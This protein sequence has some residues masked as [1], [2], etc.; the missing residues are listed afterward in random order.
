[1]RTIARV[2]EDPEMT[3][4][5]EM[6]RMIRL[7]RRRTLSQEETTETESLRTVS[8][9]REERDLRMESKVRRE[10]DLRTASRVREEREI[11]MESKRR[12]ER[13]LRTVNRVR[14]E[15]DLRRLR[16]LRR[17][18]WNNELYLFYF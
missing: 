3:N 5:R 13:D 4:L 18:D 17:T 10:R 15:K 8:R 6:S 14:E 2:K 9:V 7:M 12:E 11:R 16:M 1:M